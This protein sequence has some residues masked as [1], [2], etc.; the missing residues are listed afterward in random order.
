MNLDHY[1]IL[2]IKSDSKWI[3]DLN[4]RSETMKLLQ[5]NIIDNLDT[6]LEDGFFRSD[7]KYKGKK[8]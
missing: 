6:G 4:L 7:I 5:E 1:L 8:S 2:H 3:K